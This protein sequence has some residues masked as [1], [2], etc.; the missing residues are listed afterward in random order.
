[1]KWK[2]K[3]DELASGGARARIYGYEDT[4]AHAARSIAVAVGW[5]KTQI[6]CSGGEDRSYEKASVRRSG[7]P[8]LDASPLS[9]AQPILVHTADGYIGHRQ[10]AL[11]ATANGRSR[12]K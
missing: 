3:P 7:R 4:E 6:Q 1:M 12:P 8:R 9:R 10:I 11:V 5:G 2:K